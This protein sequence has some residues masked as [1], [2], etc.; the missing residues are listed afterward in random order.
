[1]GLGSKHRPIGDARPDPDDALRAVPA[2]PCAKRDERGGVK[3]SCPAFLTD[4]IQE[5][6]KRQRPEKQADVA[7]KDRDDKSHF[8]ERS[9]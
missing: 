4:E 9:V 8:A 1:M 3:D 6:D 7:E 2:L 5:Q